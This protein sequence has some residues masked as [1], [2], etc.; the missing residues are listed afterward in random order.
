MT[1]PATTDI[2]HGHPSEAPRHG[3]TTDTTDTSQVNTT[4]TTTDTTDS[5][6][7]GHDFPLYIGGVGP[8]AVQNCPE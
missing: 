5:L 8:V 7:H 4:D 2:H 3:R 1:P 6:D